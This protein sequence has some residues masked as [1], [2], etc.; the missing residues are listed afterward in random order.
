MAILLTVLK[1]I[2]IV[3]LSFLGLLLVLLLVFLITPF[4]YKVKGHYDD[5]VYFSFTASYALH[6][7]SIRVLYSEELKYTIRILGIPLSLKNK[8]KKDKTAADN[9]SP[10]EETQAVD[11]NEAEKKKSKSIV[12]ILNLLTEDNTKKAW[13]VCK[14]RLGKLLKALMPKHLKL[15]ITYGLNDPYYTGLAACIYDVFYIY[16]SKVINIY[17]VYDEKTIKVYGK[18]KGR[19]YPVVFLINML[20]VILDKNCRIFYKNITDR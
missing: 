19:I 3:I 11:S 10:S 7:L 1:V 5:N 20:A 9:S 17:P 4:R 13:E 18:C 6:I 8:P 15:D 2:G 14:K 16:L 12:H